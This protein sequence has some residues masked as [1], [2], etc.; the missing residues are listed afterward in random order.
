MRKCAEKGIQAILSMRPSR[1]TDVVVRFGLRAVVHTEGKR[2][3]YSADGA[4][5]SA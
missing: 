5:G 4:S 1:R 3:T 2:R